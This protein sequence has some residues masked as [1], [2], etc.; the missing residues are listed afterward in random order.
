MRKINK[1]VTTLIRMGFRS[2]DLVYSRDDNDNP[3]SKA[4]EV[5]LNEIL[6]LDTSAAPYSCHEVYDA[7]RGGGVRI[8]LRNEEIISLFT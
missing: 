4:W 6:P 8:Y 2:V 3:T 5:F 7:D 1:K